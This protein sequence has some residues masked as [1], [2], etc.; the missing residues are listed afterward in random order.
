[1]SRICARSLLLAGLTMLLLFTVW[2]MA[3]RDLVAAR[4]ELRGVIEAND[5]LKMTLGEMTITLTAKDRE[6]QRLVHSP[7]AGREQRPTA[8]GAARM[9]N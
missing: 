2:W 5:F 8:A 4:R 3:R 6:I 7:C 9:L 1:M